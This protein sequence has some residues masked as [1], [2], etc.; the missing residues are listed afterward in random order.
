MAKEWH[1]E[2]VRN[3]NWLAQ[4]HADI[5]QR[6]EE[7]RTIRI[8]LQN[9]KDMGRLRQ[10]QKSLHTKTLHDIERFLSRFA[11][12]PPAYSHGCI[13]L[14]LPLSILVLLLLWKMV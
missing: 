1:K 2:M 10:K 4:L 5:Y 6:R 13:L 3:E 7:A 14:L 8:S 11:P 12:P 9:E